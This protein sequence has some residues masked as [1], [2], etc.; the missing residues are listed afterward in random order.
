MTSLPTTGGIFLYSQ[1]TDMRKGFSGLAGI[2]RRESK[3]SG[4]IVF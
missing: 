3:V 2:I 1:P 4:V